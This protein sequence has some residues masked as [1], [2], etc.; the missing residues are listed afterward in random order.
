MATRDGW[1]SSGARSSPFP[2]VFLHFLSHLF[3]FT[4]L[5]L[6]ASHKV[7]H[8]SIAYNLYC[9]LASRHCVLLTMKCLLKIQS[10]TALYVSAAKV[11]E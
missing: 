9:F 2:K 5:S 10:S 3:F 11:V 7:R 1:N 4:R 6:L 8:C